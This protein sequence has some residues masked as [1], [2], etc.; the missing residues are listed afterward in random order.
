VFILVLLIS[1]YV[2]LSSMCAGVAFPVFLFLFFDT[3]SMFLKVF[4]VL[5]AVAIIITHRNNISRLLK[6]E[7]SKLLRKGTKS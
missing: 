5:V 6:G 2:S 7:E 4:S 1:G 3:P